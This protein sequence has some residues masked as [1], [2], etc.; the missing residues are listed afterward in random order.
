[1]NE[2]HQ[3]RN[4]FV[5]TDMTGVIGEQIVR[6]TGL[7]GAVD[8]ILDGTFNTDIRFMVFIVQMEKTIVFVAGW[9]CTKRCFRAV[10]LYIRQKVI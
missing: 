6:I 9:Q 10:F 8:C 2:F 4:A 3:S 7:P 5:R 1:M